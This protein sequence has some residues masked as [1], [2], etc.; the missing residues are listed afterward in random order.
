MRAL[1]EVVG[2]AMSGFGLEVAGADG[3]TLLLDG[4][5]TAVSV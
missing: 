3:G 5:K 1:V 2:V 4:F